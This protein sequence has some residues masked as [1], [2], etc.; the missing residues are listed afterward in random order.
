[1][2]THDAG[3]WFS[4]QIVGPVDPL[5][6]MF[7]YEVYLTD[8]RTGRVDRL[9]T[10]GS[11][12]EGG[13]SLIYRAYTPDGYQ[14]GEEPFFGLGAAAE[15]LA[16]DL[17]SYEIHQAPSTVD[18]VAAELRAAH[19]RFNPPPAPRGLYGEFHEEDQE[20]VLAVE[21]WPDG[22]LKS[23]RLFHP[24]ECSVGRCYAAHLLEED[25]GWIEGEFPVFFGPVPAGMH[26]IRAWAEA[27]DTDYGLEYDAGITIIEEVPA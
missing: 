13:H 22:R 14:L 7:D 16:R 23:W 12:T 25:E 5:F 8:H 11:S 19:D 20:H 1:M 26:R 3:P 6:G 21:R 2:T 17:V 27:A 18:R 4:Y 24:P 15:R 10:V 9:G